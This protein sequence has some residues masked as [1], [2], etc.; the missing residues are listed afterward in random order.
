MPLESP[1]FPLNSSHAFE[2]FLSTDVANSPCGLESTINRH[3][4]KDSPILAS[5]G[6]EPN[7]SFAKTK[8]VVKISGFSFIK[9]ATKLYLPFDAALRSVLP[10]VD[11]MV[12]AL[13]DCD[14]DDETAKLISAIKSDKIKIIPTVWDYEK[15]PRGR[16]FAHQTDIAKAA[17]TGDWLFYIQG[18]EVI[19][20]SDQALI[21]DAC[22]KNLPRSEVEGILF[23]YL[24]FYGDY[25]HYQIAHGWY[26]KE[27]RIIR[28]D[29][30][31]H[32]WRDAQ[33]FRRIPDFDG[34]D[35][36]RKENTYKLKVVESGARVFHYGW[37][38]PPD[39][40]LRK[41]RE[42]I[43]NYHRNEVAPDRIHYGP[44]GFLKRYEGTHPAV[45]KEWIQRF[46][47][48]SDLNYSRTLRPGEGDFKHARLQNRFLTFL[49]QRIMGGR[50]IGDF[51]NYEL[52][53]SK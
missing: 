11:E 15:Y 38:R 32:S 10:L 26:K 24:H 50:G 4:G 7:Q 27:I 53:S 19:H 5:I 3:V 30:E 45:M 49:E 13:G 51:K 9:N 2:V 42:R 46:D 17:C 48:G 40:L 21:L 34:L 8:G 20:E 25:D 37:V 35:Y 23:D 22:R 12:I 52:I 36:H 28:N 41:K 14:A 29:P 6:L 44:L 1:R 47:W 18:D 39:Y 43:E 33:S 16:E 31:I